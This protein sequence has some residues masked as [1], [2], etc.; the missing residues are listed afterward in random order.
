M[1]D[2]TLSMPTSTL[3][4]QNVVAMG[5]PSSGGVSAGIIVLIVLLIVAALAAV[6][7]LVYKLRQRRRYEKHDGGAD[8]TP[9]TEK[10]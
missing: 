3:A 8:A 9:M 1:P 4:S 6:G 10:Q 2:S 7:F 5:S